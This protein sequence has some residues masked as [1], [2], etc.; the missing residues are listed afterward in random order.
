MTLANFNPAEFLCDHWQKQPLLVRGAFAHWVN[1]VAPD[2]LAGLA[3]EPVVEARLA[4]AR[5]GGWKLEHG[6]FEAARFAELPPAG[7]TLLVQAVDHHVPEVAAMIDAF[8]FVPNWRIDDVMV[9]Y[10]ADGGGVGPH[11]DQ[12]DV[13]LIQGLGRRRW[14]VGGR[15]NESTPLRPHADL[16]LI[17]GFA[18]VDEWVLEP[19]DMLYV[20]PGFAHDGV[21]VGDNCMTY[22]VGFRAPTRAEL[23][24][25]W[26]AHASDG[27]GEDE[28]YAD[29]DLTAQHAPGEIAPE[30][31]ARLHALAI[32]A[33]ADRAAFARWFGADATTPKYPE[34]DWSPDD[35]LA[36]HAVAAKVAAGAALIRN[37]A[38]RFAFV[39]GD[40]G[41]TTVFVDGDA[42][43]CP[44]GL[45][46]FV[47]R[48]TDP[49]AELVGE[50]RAAALIAALIARGAVA[51]ADGA[52]RTDGDVAADGADA[53][54]G[55]GR[56]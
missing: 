50:P 38:S 52:D 40:G 11:F 54:G 55:P 18:A 49:R 20:P 16:R 5:K 30:A 35:P 7:W 15:C 43:D 8:R 10:A 6:P 41:A 31:I 32:D 42:T 44:P 53:A 17:D 37:P 14:Q 56:D 47:T 13:F 21:A 19:G 4:V 2:A 23:I 33:L 36:P 46:N 24:E 45:E 34:I 12:Y 39:R 1:P 27:S 51:F 9:S 29:P 28:R 3:C 25:G 48:L 26:A 22:S